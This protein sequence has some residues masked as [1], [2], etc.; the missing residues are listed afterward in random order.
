[1]A[2]SRADPSAM[3][4]GQPV[5]GPDA[6]GLRRAGHGIANLCTRLLAPGVGD[7]LFGF[8][9]YPIAPL[10]REMHR[11]RWMRG[12][13]F[14]P[15][16]AIRLARAGIPAIRLPAPVRYLTPAQGGVSHFHYLKDNLRLAA[17]YARLALSP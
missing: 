8:R 3:I 13:D 17:M 5:F 2:A 16:A 14:D 15:E 9:L 11:T 12:F 1:M 7:S 10:R 6:P 4:L